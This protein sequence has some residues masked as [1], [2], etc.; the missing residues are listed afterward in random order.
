MVENMGIY[1]RNH[2][3]HKQTAQNIGGYLHFDN[4]FLQRLSFPIN[5]ENNCIRK[6]FDI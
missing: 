4:A 5:G 1:T 3:I 2:R 6:Y